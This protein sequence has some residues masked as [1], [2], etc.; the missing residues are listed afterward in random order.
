MTTPIIASFRWSKEEFLRVQLLAVRFSRQGRMIYRVCSFLGV[1]IL[2]GGII[3]LCK[4]PAALA[5]WLFPLFFSAFFF[6][7]PLFT[8]RAALKLFAQKSDREMDVTWEIS[9]DC[10]RTKTQLAA[11][12]IQWEL[13]QKIIRVREGFLMYPSPNAFHW[14]PMHAFRDGDAERFAE[15]AET[16][17]KDY[18]DA[19]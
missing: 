3:N 12:E 19:T 4:Q 11:S 18:R 14:L 1:M 7:I 17:V 13:F 15:L 2:L 10:V 5:G 8:R 6:S 9:T 16:K